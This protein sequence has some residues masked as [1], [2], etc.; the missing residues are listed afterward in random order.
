M[1]NEAARAVV[2]TCNIKHYKDQRMP[3]IAVAVQGDVIATPG[4]GLPTGADSGT[5]TA[6][7]VNYQTY[8]KLKAGGNV[9][10]QSSCT[11]TFAGVNSS[12]SPVSS[13][14]TVTLSAG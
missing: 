5:W 8:A 4:T 11:F 12:G 1:Y 6:G 14:S 9:A 10:N 2:Y 7:P 3:P 13:S